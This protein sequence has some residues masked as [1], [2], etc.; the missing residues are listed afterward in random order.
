MC[1]CE[2]VW[3]KWKQITVEIRNS[4]YRARVAVTRIVLENWTHTQISLKNCQIVL[5]LDGS[6]G[7]GGGSMT[8]DTAARYVDFLKAYDN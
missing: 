1:V 2:F 8:R 3:W 5:H 4:A 7:G 6:G